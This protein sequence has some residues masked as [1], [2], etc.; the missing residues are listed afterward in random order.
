M[1]VK[2][3][4]DKSLIAL[5]LIVSFINSSEILMNK[6]YVENIIGSLINRIINSVVLVLISYLV[7]SLFIRAI[8]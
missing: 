3:T 6:N 7:V 1:S 8:T 4:V 2:E 5:V